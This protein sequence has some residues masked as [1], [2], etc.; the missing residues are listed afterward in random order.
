MKARMA[1]LAS[2]REN[3]NEKFEV[4]RDTLVSLTDTLQERMTTCLG[5]AEGTDLE[6][7]PEEI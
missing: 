1:F 7:I 2:Q 6:E 5:N 4:L 3:N